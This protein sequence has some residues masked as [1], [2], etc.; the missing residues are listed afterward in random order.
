MKIRGPQNGLKGGIFTA[1]V[2]AVWITGCDVK[3]DNNVTC[4]KK[5]CTAA[6][7][8]KGFETGACN[9]NDGCV[10]GPADGE[11]YRWRDDSSDSHT[12]SADTEDSDT[13]T[14]TETESGT[15]PPNDAG[16]DGGA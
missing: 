4:A 2:I 13:E 6:C 9:K 15:T 3:N 10:C 5:D 11:P 8:T 1:I 7:E 16:V 12:E 14:E